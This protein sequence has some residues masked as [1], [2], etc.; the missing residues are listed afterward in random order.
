MYEIKILSDKEFEALPYPELEMS[1]GVAD[2]ETNTAYVRDTHSIELNK[3]LIDHELEHLIEGHDGEHSDHYKHG[4][5]YKNFGQTLQAIAPALAFVPYLGVGGSM[6]ASGVGSGISRKSEKKQINAQRDSQEASMKQQQDSFGGFN[7]S[8]SMPS[9]TPNIV[10]P[11]GSG[12]SGMPSTGGSGGGM[13]G[14]LSG[15][16]GSAV[17]RVRGFFSGRNPIGGF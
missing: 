13:G 17:E 8:D 3:Y 9:A 2:P 10:T 16:G 14:N 15:E 6:I 7:A 1:L 11:G 4:V 12:G 5:Y